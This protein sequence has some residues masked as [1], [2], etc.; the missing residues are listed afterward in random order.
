MGLLELRLTIFTRDYLKLLL[1]EIIFKD[2]QS[3]EQA[4]NSCGPLASLPLSDWRFKI[5]VICAIP[6]TLRKYRRLF[7]YFDITK[8]SLKCRSFIFQVDEKVKRAKTYL[9]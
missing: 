5:L 3:S 6:P 8:D 9:K 4:A 7:A 1:H 2:H